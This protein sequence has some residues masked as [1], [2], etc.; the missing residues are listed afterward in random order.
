ME[1]HEFWARTFQSKKSLYCGIPDDQP[2]FELGE[3]LLG[4]EVAFIDDV[5]LIANGFNRSNRV[6]KHNRFTGELLACCKLGPLLKVRDNSAWATLFPVFRIIRNSRYLVMPPY[7]LDIASLEVVFNLDDLIAGSDYKFDEAA[8]STLS[9]QFWVYEVNPKEQPGLW[10]VVDLNT[11]Q[12]ALR[13]FD[14]TMPMWLD[15][16]S[17]RIACVS[18]S[19]VQIRSFDNNEVLHR[20][21]VNNLYDMMCDTLG[22][23]VSV[24]DD[25]QLLSVNNLSVISRLS[26]SGLACH[27]LKNQIYDSSSPLLIIHAEIDPL[28]PT[29]QLIVYN[30]EENRVLWKKPVR[31]YEITSISGDLIFVEFD[32]KQNLAIDKWNGEVVW[33]QASFFDVSY[34]SFFGHQ[35][36]AIYDSVYGAKIRCYQWRENYISPARPTESMPARVSSEFEI[37]DIDQIDSTLAEPVPINNIGQ[38]EIAKLPEPRWVDKDQFCHRRELSWDCSVVS[39]DGQWELSLYQ[40]DDEYSDVGCYIFVKNVADSQSLLLQTRSGSWFT[41]DLENVFGLIEYLVWDESGISFWVEDDGYIRIEIDYEKGIFEREEIGIDDNVFSEFWSVGKEDYDS[42]FRY[43]IS[44]VRFSDR[45]RAAEVVSTGR[46][47]PNSEYKRLPDDAHA[48]SDFTYM[49]TDNVILGVKEDG[50]PELIA[51]TANEAFTQEVLAALASGALTLPV[52]LEGDDL[53]GKLR[54]PAITSDE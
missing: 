1:I 47:W 36:Y 24:E 29:P 43:K 50:N 46:Y 22:I 45:T 23:V 2:V 10:C 35:I 30:W 25:L 44:R 40:I 5:M 16:S 12:G 31:N 53:G 37:S 7:L 13:Q 28:V 26:D 52:G 4:G 20:Y 34:L 3:K 41:D 32:G 6:S 38:D 8:R 54:V 9:E 14:A 33:T 49:F 27:K 17:D 51:S 39:P 48:S 42:L 19:E 18:G 21:H 11:M 15:G